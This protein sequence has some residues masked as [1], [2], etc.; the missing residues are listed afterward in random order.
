MV[1]LSA[2]IKG[3]K[4]E[5][6]LKLWLVDVKLIIKHLHLRATPLQ[7]VLYHL[8]KLLGRSPNKNNFCIASF[9]ILVCH[10]WRCSKGQHPK[11]LWEQSQKLIVAV[12]SCCRLLFA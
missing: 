10:A 4:F 8:V 6:C 11:I 3:E 9:I 7:S 5:D 12:C 2:C 1:T